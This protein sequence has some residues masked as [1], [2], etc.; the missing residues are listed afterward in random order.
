MNNWSGIEPVNLLMLN[1]TARHDQIKHVNL[2]NNGVRHN[3]KIKSG[4]ENRQ[5]NPPTS[6]PKL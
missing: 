4:K 5:L 3:T 6:I 2:A 1:Y